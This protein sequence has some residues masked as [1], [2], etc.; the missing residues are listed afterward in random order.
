M[1]T[2][3]SGEPHL[4]QLELPNDDIS[5]EPGISRGK[6]LLMPIFTSLTQSSVVAVVVAGL[7]E[8]LPYDEAYQDWFR[9]VAG[10]L[11]TS[12][13]NAKVILLSALPPLSS[14]PYSCTTPRFA[15]LHVQATSN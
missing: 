15:S 14:L 4:V 2:I 6:V 3:N 7:N 10:H 12:L 11:S 1:Q 8:Y 5:K 9:L 13:T